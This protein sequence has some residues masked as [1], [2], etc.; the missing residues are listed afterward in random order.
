M[1]NILII[2]VL[3]F[4]SCADNE[5]ISI[6]QLAKSDKTLNIKLSDNVSPEM[7]T[8]RYIEK[9]SRRLLICLNSINSELLY[10]DIDSIVLFKN[11]SFTQVSDFAITS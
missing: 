9:G 4:V 1:K 2:V 11:L 10:Y 6:K 8:M 7:Q 5:V 3:L